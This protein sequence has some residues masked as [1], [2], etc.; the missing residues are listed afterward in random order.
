MG[1]KATSPSSLYPDSVRSSGC[2][3]DIKKFIVTFT[4]GLSF[5]CNRSVFDPELETFRWALEEYRVK[6]LFVKW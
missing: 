6:N 1:A 5:M 2:S 3:P 4:K